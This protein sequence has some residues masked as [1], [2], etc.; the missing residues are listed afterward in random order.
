MNKYIADGVQKGGRQVH[1]GWGTERWATNTLQV[2]IYSMALLQYDY[3]WD[4]SWILM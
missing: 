4:D 1:S 2:G 3:F